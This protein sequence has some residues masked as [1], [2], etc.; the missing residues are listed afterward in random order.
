MGFQFTQGP[1]RTGK[2]IEQVANII[3]EVGQEKRFLGFLRR[4]GTN[5]NNYGPFAPNENDDPFASASRRA[6]WRIGWSWGNSV[7]NSM[8]MTLHQGWQVIF[9]VFDEG[10]SRSLVAKVE[11]QSQRREVEKFV[12]E[13]FSLV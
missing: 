2:S 1:V 9:D 11:G 7:T 12:A 5:P 3:K 13:V 4:A 8:G 10:G 6:D